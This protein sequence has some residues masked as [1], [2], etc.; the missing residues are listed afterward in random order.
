M[1]RSTCMRWLAVSMTLMA[2]GCSEDDPS[3]GE[4]API[5][6]DG[7]PA[8][9]AAAGASAGMPSPAG[10]KPTAATGAPSAGSATTPGDLPQ[11]A[12]D[13]PFSQLPAECKG[14]EVSGLEFSPGG[15]VLPNICAPFHGSYNNPYAIR[16]VDAD[17]SFETRWKGDEFCILP[18]SPD[19][20]TQLHVGPKNY[21]DGEDVAKFEMQ[22][23]EEINTY[24]F[25]NADAAEPHHYYRT[26]YRMRDGSHHMIISMLAGDREDGWAGPSDTGTDR[27]VGSTG[28][29]GAQRTDSDRPQGTLEIPPEDVGIGAELAANQQFSFNLH[30]MNRFDEPI[31]REAW[32][33]IWYQDDVTHVARSATLFG[34]PADIAIAP[35]EHKVLHYSSTVDGSV[36]ILSY[37]GH[38]H[39]ST[40]RFAIWIQRSSGET[41][42]AY[43]SFD[44]QAMP[45]YQYD[46]ISQNPVPDVDARQDGGHSGMLELNTGDQVHFV[47]D[48]TN[49]QDQALHFANELLTGEMCIVFGSGVGDGSFGQVTRVMD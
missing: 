11:L 46:S 37:F 5:G 15:D 22:P 48:I 38:R 20:G 26:N 32:V 34:T 4:T 21:D 10:A 47:C 28:F 14:F 43:E 18:P 24:Y 44:W 25:L 9:A 6:S 29:G 7:S 30:F 19:Q 49:R 1:A 39:V 36:R 12:P 8:S 23:G 3:T 41:V 45:V 35:M 40:D 33:N 27:G 16:C 13:T 2:V 31:L 17:P 42:P